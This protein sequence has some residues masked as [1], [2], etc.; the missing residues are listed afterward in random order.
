MRF[1]SERRA[2]SNTLKDARRKSSRNSVRIASAVLCVLQNSREALF[3]VSA[4]L[5]GVALGCLSAVALGLC[6]LHAFVHLGEHLAG[7]KKMLLGF[8]QALLRRRKISVD[9]FSTTGW[10][11]GGAGHEVDA[12]RTTDD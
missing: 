7:I 1:S 12:T 9:A 6:K 3:R 5:L 10:A 2:R 11:F 4:S 8:A